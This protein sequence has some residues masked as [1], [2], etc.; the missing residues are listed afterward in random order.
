[1]PSEIGR[2]YKVAL[3]SLQ[4]LTRQGFPPPAPSPRCLAQQYQIFPVSELITMLHILAATM[5]QWVGLTS[6]STLSFQQQ[7]ESLVIRHTTASI[8]NV[9]YIPPGGYTV[10]SDNVPATNSISFCRVFGMQPYPTNNTVQFEVWLP[11]P[12]AYNERF[13]VVGKPEPKLTPINHI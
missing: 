4:Y 1:M 10:N 9:T 5:A 7:C 3:L 12:A 8:A 13:L 6:A 2:I 11:D